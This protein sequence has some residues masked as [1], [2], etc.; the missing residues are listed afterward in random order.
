VLVDFWTYCFGDSDSAFS[1]ERQ[2]KIKT[3]RRP[4]LV[5]VDQ[6]NR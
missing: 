2:Q 4:R 5:V 6:V 3:G 1:R